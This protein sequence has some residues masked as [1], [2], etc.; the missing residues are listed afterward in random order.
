MLALSAKQSLP[1]SSKFIRAA[2][3]FTDSFAVEFPDEKP[4]PTISS[5][6]Y[7]KLFCQI[8]R[9]CSYYNST[10]KSNFRKSDS[11]I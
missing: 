10:V 4:G 9:N 2:L 1:K 5:A 8:F 3:L 11:K 6:I 7:A